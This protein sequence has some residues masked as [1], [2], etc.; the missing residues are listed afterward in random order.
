MAVQVPRQ[1]VYFLLS[2]FFLVQGRL[3]WG[4][5]FVVTLSNASMSVCGLS[6]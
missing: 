3:P 6:G 5:G 4:P 1:M 2:L